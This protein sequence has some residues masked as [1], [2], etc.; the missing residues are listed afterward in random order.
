MGLDAG[1]PGD[2]KMVNRPG[3][4]KFYA[5]PGSPYVLTAPKKAA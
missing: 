5:E 1:N 4:I 2:C 3:G